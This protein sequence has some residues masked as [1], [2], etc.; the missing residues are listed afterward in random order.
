[1]TSRSSSIDGLSVLAESAYLLLR[2]DSDINN[3]IV[4]G[5]A[6]SLSV[7]RSHWEVQTHRSLP[8]ISLLSEEHLFGEE[9]ELT[10]DTVSL[11]VNTAPLSPFI[12]CDILERVKPKYFIT[13]SLYLV[14]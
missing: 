4:I 11:L 12:S 13:P 3:V 7:L 8:T 1:M 2:E 9:N 5:D 14:S 10:A 6:T